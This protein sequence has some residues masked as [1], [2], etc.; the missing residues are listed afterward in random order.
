MSYTHAQLTRIAGPARPAAHPG[1]P[2]SAG[3]G[4]P[5][6]AS[7]RRSR[8][9]SARC[10]CGSST[11]SSCRPSC[12]SPAAPRAASRKASAPHARFP[13][14]GA[15]TDAHPRHLGALPRLR[16][17]PRRRRHPRL[18][19][20]GRAPL[21]AQERRRVPA[22]RHRFLPRGREARSRGSRRRR[23]LREADAEAR[24]GADHGP[25]RLPPYL[26]QLP[27][28]DAQ[29]PRREAVGQ[30]NHRLATR[31]AGPEDPLHRAPPGARG[32]RVLHRS[33]AESGHPHRRRRRRVGDLL[34][35]HGRSPRRRHVGFAP[36]PRSPLPAFAGNALLDLHGVPRLPRQ[37]GRIQG[38]GPRRVRRAHLPGRGPRDPA[39]HRG[40]RVRSRPRLLRVPPLRL[41]IL[42][43]QVHRNVR[44]APRPLGPDRPGQRRRP[45]LRG[46][47]LL[48][49]AGPRGDAGRPGLPAPGRDR[50]LRSLPRRRRRA[51]WLRE[52]AHL[53]RVGIF[54]RLRPERAR[55]RGLRDGRGALG[56]S[57]PLQAPA[58]RRARPSLLGTG[59]G[60]RREHRGRG[61][62]A[63]RPPPRRRRG[64][65]PRRRRAL[66]RPH[67]RMGRGAL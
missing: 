60:R 41:A 49:P 11:S 30:G 23:L 47:R 48:R 14:R 25:A 24:A 64:D 43:G 5:I 21:P 17:G 9:S 53:A 56:G 40:R 18:R 31:R 2:G 6:C 52:R 27:E 26:P 37:P 1:R 55:G 63:R 33:H 22:R 44:A 16:R 19:R 3:C 35:G 10:S 58:S 39:P 46:R 59:A 65:P 12:F 32:D 50:P 36:P 42:F 15:S 51:E 61:R 62:I 20:P 7:R 38:D 34:D 29:P 67:R 13:T 45:P 28:G 54:P 4:R 57:A 8:A 66:Q